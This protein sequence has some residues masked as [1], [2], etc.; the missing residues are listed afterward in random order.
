MD[1]TREVAK[2][3]GRPNTEGIQTVIQGLRTKYN[4][5]FDAS[6]LFKELNQIKAA[7]T[8]WT[9]NSLA[10][11]I[12]IALAIFLISMIIWK[13]SVSKTNPTEYPTPSA[14]PMPTPNQPQ[15]PLSKLVTNNQPP[16]PKRPSPFISTSH[17][18]TPQ[19][20]GE[21]LEQHSKQGHKQI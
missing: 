6:E 10:A 15:R 13:K 7:E 11:M 19:R 3:F 5:E 4:G 16:N 17:R 8:H 14:S 1:C 20:K 18:E 9:F 2:L 21:I 12:G